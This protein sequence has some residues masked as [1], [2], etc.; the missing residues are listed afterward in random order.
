[1]IHELVL[2]R[3]F[4]AADRAL[5]DAAYAAYSGQECDEGNDWC[6]GAD[7]NRSGAA[8]EDDIAFIEAAD[9]CVR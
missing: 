8:D 4:T 5:F 3:H 7:L 6:E 9:G 2:E 1:M